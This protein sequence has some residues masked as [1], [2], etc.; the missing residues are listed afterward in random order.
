M[1]SLVIESAM[2]PMSSPRRVEIQGLSQEASLTI[3][4]TF[5]VPFLRSTGGNVTIRWASV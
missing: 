3:A 1:K 2:T 4:E 5:I